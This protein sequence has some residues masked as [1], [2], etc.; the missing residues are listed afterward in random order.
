MPKVFLQELQQ[1]AVEGEEGAS[2]CGD[3]AD[4]CCE[5]VR[6]ALALAVGVGLMR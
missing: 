1:Q 3:V 4:V 6:A 2:L 5:R